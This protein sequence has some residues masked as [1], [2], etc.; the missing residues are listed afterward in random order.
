[1]NDDYPIELFEWM[2][3]NDDQTLPDG[4]WQAMLEDAANTFNLLNKTQF[5]TYGSFIAYCKWS[6]NNEC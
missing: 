5:C 6:H 2:S 3:T 4:A 1:M